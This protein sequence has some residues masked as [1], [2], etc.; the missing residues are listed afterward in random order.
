M[1]EATGSYKSTSAVESLTGLDVRA[2]ASSHYADG[3]AAGDMAA[4]SRR[5]IRPDAL[6]P[7]APWK[8]G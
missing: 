6:R 1:S 8:L 4:G 2:S 3:R 7:F 5:A